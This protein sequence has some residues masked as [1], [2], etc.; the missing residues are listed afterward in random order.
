MEEEPE[1]FCGA[2]EAGLEVFEGGVGF[3]MEGAEGFC[4]V[5]DF[6]KAEQEEYE[7]RTA[8]QGECGGHARE[9]GEL[10][11]DCCWRRVCGWGWGVCCGAGF[12]DPG[13]EDVEHDGGGEEDA[14]AD[15]ESHLDEAGEAG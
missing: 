12:T 15:E 14:C 3:A 1:G 2:A 9:R 4:A 13:E 11:G 5:V 7:E 10:G 6:G 8:E